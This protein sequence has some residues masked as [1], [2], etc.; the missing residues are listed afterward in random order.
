MAR[1]KDESE[2]GTPSE[3]GEGVVR[4]GSDGTLFQIN[5]WPNEY[6][7]LIWI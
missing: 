3:E 2:V 1:R 5:Q 6:D 7:N 4:A